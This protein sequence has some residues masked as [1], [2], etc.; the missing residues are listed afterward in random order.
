MN[1]RRLKQESDIDAH[2]KV[3][4]EQIDRALEVVDETLSLTGTPHHSDIKHKE[5]FGYQCV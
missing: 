4:A 3:V 5:L 2:K 1:T